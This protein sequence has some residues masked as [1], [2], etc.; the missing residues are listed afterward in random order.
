MNEIKRVILWIALAV[1]SL[2][3]ASALTPIAPEND[4]WEIFSTGY[5][6]AT[7]EVPDIESRTETS[8]S[9]YDTAPICGEITE[10]YQQR[11]TALSLAQTLGELSPVFGAM[12]SGIGR[13]SI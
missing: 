6:A 12:Y 2:L 5:D 9:G 11:R 13:P 10:K 1:A 4:V 8:I 3:P 7:A